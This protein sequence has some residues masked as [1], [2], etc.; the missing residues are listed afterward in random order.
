MWITKAMRKGKVLD[1]TG[2]LVSKGFENPL[3]ISE[4]QKDMTH[5]LFQER[6]VCIDDGLERRRT[7]RQAKQ[8]TAC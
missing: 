7:Q 6:S 8:I 3:K 1:E 2:K 4:K 5:Y